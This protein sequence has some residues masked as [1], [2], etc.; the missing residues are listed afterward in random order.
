MFLPILVQ[1][2]SQYRDSK[3]QELGVIE[4]VTKPPTWVNPLV[5]LS[6]KD[7]SSVQISVDM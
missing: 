5:A 1:N 3:L 7:A 6:Q 2:L 4:P